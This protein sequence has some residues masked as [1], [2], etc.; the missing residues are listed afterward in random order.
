MIGVVEPYVASGKGSGFLVGIL[1]A[2]FSAFSAALGGVL[3][4][5]FLKELNKCCVGVMAEKLGDDGM[6]MFIYACCYLLVGSIRGVLMF[7]HK[8]FNLGVP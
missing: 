3:S 6:P 2:Q 4:A 8:G 7:D 1:V 5:S